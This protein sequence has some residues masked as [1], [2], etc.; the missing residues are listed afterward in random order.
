[1]RR[2]KNITFVIATA[3]AYIADRC[4]ELAIIHQGCVI[5]SGAT[6]KL[7]ANAKADVII[8]DGVR[9][10]L[11][12]SKIKKRF[13]AVVEEVEGHIKFTSADGNNDI[14]D[15]LAEHGPEVGA[16]YL[17]RPGLEDLLDDLTRKK[18]Q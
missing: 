1:M 8:I 3:N 15:L 13:A 11:I 10:P 4:D 17:R 9:N 2:E 18:E 14:I 12:K 5:A 6:S 7:K 16:I